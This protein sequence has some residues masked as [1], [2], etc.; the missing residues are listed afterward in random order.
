MSTHDG[1]KRLFEPRCIELAGQFD[2]A[3]G[4]EHRR[5]TQQIPKSFLL[6]RKLETLNYYALCL[7]CFLTSTD[8]KN[9]SSNHPPTR[10]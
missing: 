4:R 3:S 1:A 6:W 8:L 2:G 5:F 7:H 10:W 9:I